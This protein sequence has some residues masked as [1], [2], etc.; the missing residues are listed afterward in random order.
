M[1][2]LNTNR[3]VYFHVRAASVVDLV[4]VELRRMFKFSTWF[5]YDSSVLTLVV[6][7]IGIQDGAIQTRRGGM[8]MQR[9]VYREALF[10]FLDDILLT[11]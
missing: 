1:E 8:Q 10:I 3:S 4:V 9:D 6:R 11:R 5:R 7:G 2:A